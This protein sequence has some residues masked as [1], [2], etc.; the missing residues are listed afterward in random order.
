MRRRGNGGV[1][2]RPDRVRPEQIAEHNTN[3]H[4]AHLQTYHPSQNT[5]LPG[6]KA[7]LTSVCAT[8]TPLKRCVIALLLMTNDDNIKGLSVTSF[9]S[10]ISLTVATEK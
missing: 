2:Y 6:H 1:F 5:G 10:R 8:N 3:T 7:A 4:L 9:P